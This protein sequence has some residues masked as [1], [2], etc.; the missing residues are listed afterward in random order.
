M[1]A[2][3]NRTK[4]YEE[5]TLSEARRNKPN[6]KVHNRRREALSG[7]ET[8]G[9]TGSW[10]RLQLKADMLHCT[11]NLAMGHLSRWLLADIAGRNQGDT[12]SRITGHPGGP[13]GMN[14]SQEYENMLL[15]RIGAKF[16]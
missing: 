11:G 3:I 1:A 12:A 8:S 15:Y 9:K 16:G 10:G 4:D 5:C 7:Y 6:F 2:N 13:C 14:L